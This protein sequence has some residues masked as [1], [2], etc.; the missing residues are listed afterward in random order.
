MSESVTA[1]Y[2]NTGSVITVQQK[3]KADKDKNGSQ[4]NKEYV[5]TF[6]FIAMN[7]RMQER[8]ECLSNH[9]FQNCQKKIKCRCS[10]AHQRI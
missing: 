7:F 6:S 3:K 8:A 4:K 1:M 2:P 5:L 9:V 10:V